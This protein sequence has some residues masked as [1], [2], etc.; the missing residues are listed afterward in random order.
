MSDSPMGVPEFLLDFYDWIAGINGIQTFTQMNIPTSKVWGVT[1]DNFKASYHTESHTSFNSLILKF[2][3]H[4]F[5]PVNAYWGYE[6][7]SE[8]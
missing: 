5:I 2:S 6:M 7:A 1:N 4:L 8:K 3:S